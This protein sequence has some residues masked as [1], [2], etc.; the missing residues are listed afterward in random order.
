MVEKCKF[1]GTER[2]DATLSAETGEKRL[3]HSIIFNSELFIKVVLSLATRKRQKVFV[4][5]SV[6]LCD[7]VRPIHQWRREEI[8]TATDTGRSTSQSIRPI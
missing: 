5:L 7:Q 2:L 4:S 1:S 6:F 8:E 3:L